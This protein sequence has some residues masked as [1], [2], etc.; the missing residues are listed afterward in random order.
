MVN[1]IFDI[2]IVIGVILGLVYLIGSF[3]AWWRI[4]T[5]AGEKGWKTLIPFYNAFI[6]GKIAK[7]DEFGQFVV[8]L[9]IIYAIIAFATAANDSY[10]DNGDIIATCASLICLA[11]LNIATFFIGGKFGRGAW[12]RIALCVPY[13]SVLPMLYLAFSKKCVWS[14]ESKPISFKAI[15]C[16]VVAN[17]FICFMAFVLSLPENKQGIK[18][19]ITDLVIKV[20]YTIESNP[21]RQL[22]NII[23]DIENAQKVIANKVASKDIDTTTQVA[24]GLYYMTK[25]YISWGEWIMEVAELDK[26]RWQFDNYGVYPIDIKAGQSCYSDKPLLWIDTKTGDL[27]FNPSQIT[28]NYSFLSAGLNVMFSLQRDTFKKLFDNTKD[29]DVI[30]S[31]FCQMLKAH[32]SENNDKIISLKKAEMK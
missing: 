8:I 22:K 29:G 13:I 11:V 17:I 10:F 31:E 30:K 24:P 12:F 26:M 4:F 20:A 1:L 25:D 14:G 7:S 15:I 16:F 9:L 5:K 18:Y 27:H 28:G 32:Y 6:I 19:L 23:S 21:K 2:L 3:I